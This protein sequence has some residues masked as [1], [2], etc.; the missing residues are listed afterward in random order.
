MEFTK[1][2]LLLIIYIYTYYLCFNISTVEERK[3]VSNEG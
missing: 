2:L 1:Y 3:A